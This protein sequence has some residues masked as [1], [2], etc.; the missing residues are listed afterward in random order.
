MKGLKGPNKVIVDNF[1]ALYPLRGYSDK[2]KVTSV[3]NYYN[4][5]NSI[6]RDI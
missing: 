5:S 2:N 1:N 3:L 6:N 4:R